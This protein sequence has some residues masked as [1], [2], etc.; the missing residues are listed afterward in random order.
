MVALFAG[1]L[2]LL[3]LAF[4]P[5]TYAPVL[6]RQRA[7]ALSAETGLVYRCVYDAS[8]PFSTRELIKT[9]LKVPFILLF[10]EP[11]VFVLSL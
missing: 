5:E 2:A 8:K 11:I 1:V 10:T 3:H 7:N 9:Q 4:L 6:L